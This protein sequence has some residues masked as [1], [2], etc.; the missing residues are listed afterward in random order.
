MSWTLMI[1]GTDR[2]SDYERGTLEI[3]YSLTY[4]NNTCSFN[5]FG[6]KP[7]HGDSVVISDT[8]LGAL[9]GG[10]IVVLE[11]E[12]V[13]EPNIKMRWQV[14]CNDYSE[15]LDQR[16]VVETYAAQTADYIVGDI[17]TKYVD[18][19][20]TLDAGTATAPTIEAIQFNYVPVSQA[21]TQLADY[22]GWSWNVSPGK[23]ISFFNP[24]DLMTPAPMAL[25]DGGMFTNF[26]PSIDTQNLRNR[27]YVLGGTTLSD[28]FIYEVKA[29]GAADI[30]VLPHKPHDITMTVGGVAKTIGV[31]NL[32]DEASYDYMMNYENQYVRCSSGTS[33]PGAGTTMHFEYKYDIDV[34]SMAED[35]A[36]QVAIKAIQGGTGIYEHM[37]SDD[38]LTTLTAAEAAGQA[39][40]KANADPAVS[41]TFE[42]ETPGWAPGQIVNINLPDRGINNS[43][44]VQEA[45]LART[46]AGVWW[47]TITAGGY[48]LSLP[49]VLTA[50]INNQKSAAVSESAVLHKYIYGTESVSVTDEWT[51]VTRARPYVVEA[52]SCQGVTIT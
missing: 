30:W 17:L 48:L 44:L 43:Y 2:T 45:R 26:K 51:F 42:T 31:E 16:L 24:D 9:F 36:S 18:A 41:V 50:L 1:A 14:Q 12:E 4:T 23:V 6:T 40:I 3:A 38:A 11:G 19:A 49:D 37:I 35:L 46:D 22:V 21:F 20:F 27:V 33:T 5:L 34:I 28:M 25:S 39:D 29:D 8:D 52:S 32:H 10:I 7:N 15:Q 47:W 13:D